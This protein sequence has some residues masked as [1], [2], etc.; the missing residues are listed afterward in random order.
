MRLLLFIGSTL[1]VAFPMAA[2]R[3]EY[4]TNFHDPKDII[5]DGSLVHISSERGIITIDPATG[6]QVWYD[7]FNSNLPDGRPL[8]GLDEAGG[9]WSSFLDGMFKF[10]N[11]AWSRADSLSADPVVAPR[12]QF[13]FVNGELWHA[14]TQGV[15]RRAGGTVYAYFG[16]DSPLPAPA[17][18]VNGIE[19]GQDG[20]VWVATNFGLLRYRSG[21]WS[22]W[23]QDNS[24]IACSSISEL[25]ADSS[26]VW[27]RCGGAI[28]HF[29]GDSVD[30][31]FDSDNSP[32]I[33][34]LV[35]GM[36]VAPNGELFVT[37]YSTVLFGSTPCTYCKGGLISFANGIFTRYDDTNSGI[38]K[39]SLGAVFSPAAGHVFTTSNDG[40]LYELRN[41]IWNEYF[42][43]NSPISSTHVRR[44][45]KGFDGK[46]LFLVKEYDGL[47]DAYRVW[48][49]LNACTWHDVFRSPNI[50]DAAEAHDG[51]FF[52]RLWDNKIIKVLNGA[53]VDSLMIP[54]PQPMSYDVL[55][56]EVAIDG[57]GGLWYDAFGYVTYDQMGNPTVH[58]G[59]AHSIDGT[60]TIYHEQ[61]SPL[62]G[63]L[64]QAIEIDEMDNIWV[65]TSGGV[66]RYGNN[67]W[68]T[69][70]NWTPALADR[71]ATKLSVR[72]S[73]DVWVGYFNGVAHI[74]N[75]SVINF[76]LTGTGDFCGAGAL[77]DSMM[78]LFDNYPDY[79]STYDYQ[80]SFVIAD[81]S[82]YWLSPANTHSLVANDGSIWFGNQKGIYHFMPAGTID[83]C[84]GPVWSS[85]W[86]IYPNPVTT[87][88][89]FVIGVDPNVDVRINVFA[90]DGRLVQVM[91][92]PANGM[93][94]LSFQM[95]SKAFSQGTYVI[96][97]EQGDRVVSARFVVE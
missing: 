11:G 89:L 7:Q 54:S 91:R 44:I 75:D 29:N 36:N 35:Y 8:L 4:L 80:Q 73:N 37:M 12:F 41:G 51:A 38:T 87:N 28:Q 97:L 2:Q 31:S 66:F 82:C 5:T 30:N 21:T 84:S 71:V 74:R 27:I 15:V 95:G 18:Y 6:E 43:G 94:Y 90:A 39:P 59:L 69:W 23:N 50:T 24:A 78:Y 70:L 9:L 34:S 52:V 58:E 48:A 96:S 85:Q 55:Y 33:P 32:I 45:M 88:S 81:T 79:V 49:R 60:T 53:R 14:A 86:L 77:E 47:Y 63:Q 83:G 3:W 1:F 92:P 64:I 61:N 26:G 42:L 25:D 17:Y 65:L 67:T 16:A 76:D 20:S 10:E 72:S 62:Q 57:Q 22:F 40:T 93:N 19:A 56:T 46:I 68:T 13:L